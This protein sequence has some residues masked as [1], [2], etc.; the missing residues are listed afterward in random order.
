MSWYQERFAVDS[1]LSRVKIIRA[2]RSSTR[3]FR[4]IIHRVRHLAEASQLHNE[5]HRY[6]PSHLFGTFKQDIASYNIYS[7]RII[8]QRANT[9]LMSLLT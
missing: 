6:T 2:P 7:H 8:P 9:H 3:A 5:V 1:S 4:F